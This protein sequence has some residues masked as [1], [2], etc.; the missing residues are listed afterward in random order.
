MGSSFSELI[1]TSR[2]CAG[3]HEWTNDAGVPVMSTFS[4]WSEVSGADPD[5]LQCQDCHMK[6]KFGAD[7]RGESN[8]LGFIVDNP[9]VQQNHGI[10]RRKST[11]HPHTFHGA[12]EYVTEAA[13]LGLGLADAG[14]A[15]EV[16]VGI[17][18]VN[19]GHGLPTGMPFRHA[20]L[21]VEAQFDG[22]SA[23]L[24]SGPTVPDY[25]GVGDAPEDL[26]GRPGKGYAKVLGDGTGA[27]N[28]PFWRATEVIEDTRIRGAESD[29]ITFRFAAPPE[30][31]E[32]SVTARLVYRRAFREMV[33]TKGWDVEDIE[34]ASDQA[35]LE[36]AAA[37][38]PGADAGA[39]DG[40]A[41][42][43]SEEGRQ[44]GC[45][46][47]AGAGDSAPGMALLLVALGLGRR[48]RRG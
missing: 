44:D 6:K 7:Y 18:N 24:L 12:A 38:E 30:G 14:G 17:D 29:E 1:S 21:V 26:A 35:T 10:L 13:A 22:A 8:E 27:R 39:P 31:G 43:D 25:G 42:A 34:M 46:C 20:I 16:T 15:L 28:V 4:E 23:A 45:G 3:C 36:L 11:I 9:H 2:F 5:A 37:P 19:A 33:L 40:G 48:R 41:A 32:A 47:E